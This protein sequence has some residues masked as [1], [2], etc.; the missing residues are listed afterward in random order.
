MMIERALQIP[1][2]QH[3]F[4]FGPRQTGKSTLL[5]HLF[6]EENSIF[7]NLLETDVYRRLTANPEIIRFEVEAALASQKKSHV[8][9]DEI[10]KTPQ[11]LDEIHN[12]I[13][14][15]VPCNFILS[16]SSSR[17][18]KRF[19]ANMLAGRAWTFHLYPFI[20]SEL[21]ELFQLEKVLQYG[22]LPGV[23]LRENDDEKME[24][25]RSYVDTYIKEEIE[26]E[27]NI[28]NL[29]GFLR[30]LP[31]AA[32]QNSE[33]INYSNIAREANITDKSVA[34]YFE[35]L[36]DTLMGFLIPA[37]NKS[38]RK[39][40]I[41]SPKFY[42]FYIGVVRAIKNHLDYSLTPQT[43]EYGKLFE[44]LVISEIY[45]LNKYFE[46]DFKLYYLKTKEGQEIDIIIETP[47]KT[48]VIEI[49][50]GE[51]SHKSDV[52]PLIDLLSSF[53]NASGFV[54]CLNQKPLMLNDNV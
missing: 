48:I 19:H 16:G 21:K 25:L 17:K 52:K 31:L 38:V 29:G 53:K 11:L 13:E 49:K 26:I 3:I 47:Y 28:R 5:Q 14:K 42:F 34:R 33:M 36:S 20:H 23:Y 27:A 15:K 4:L 32:G 54:F 7:Y 8:I 30:F 9:V 40:Q 6:S 24:I 50:S 39:Q 1:K 41:E 35:I 2:N 10:Q 51:V 18:L 22:S 12:L 43:Y 44:S 46:R 45:K 37:Y